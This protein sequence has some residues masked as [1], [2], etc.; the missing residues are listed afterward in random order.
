[1]SSMFDVNSIS[2]PQLQTYNDTFAPKTVLPTMA[3]V[4]PAKDTA[5]VVANK[6]ALYLAGIAATSIQTVYTTADTLNKAAEQ[7]AVTAG[8]MMADMIGTAPGIWAPPVLLPAAPDIGSL[9]VDFDATLAQVKSVVD[10]LQ[11]SWLMQYF[12]AAMP[13]GFDPLMQLILA[14]TIVTPAMQEIM[15]ERAK[16]QAVRDASRREDEAVSVWASRGFALPG[17]VVNKH[18]AQAQQ[19]LFFA[20]ADLAGQQAIKALEIQVDSVKFAAEIGVKLRVGLIEG[21]TGLVTA[22]SHLPTAAAQYASA[23]A[24]AKRAAYSAISEY[25]KSVVEASIITLRA[26]EGN[27]NLYTKNVE[28]AAD[29]MGKFMTTQVQAA[30]A[31]TDSYAKIAADAVSNM[32]TVTNIGVQAS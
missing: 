21:L 29:F 17:G 26:S 11:N 5:A 18:I 12:P 9:N 24:E 20:T 6:M 30:A 19:D 23:V 4:D 22:Y 28:I 32:N 1:M 7:S 3:A 27:A 25:Y 10:G 8:S 16:N 14:G 2:R 15:W 13:T 31:A